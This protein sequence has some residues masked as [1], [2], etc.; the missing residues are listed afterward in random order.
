MNWFVIGNSVLYLGATVDSLEKG[1]YLWAV[2]WFSYGISCA[3][4]AVIEH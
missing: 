4:L 3:I 1:H 2:V